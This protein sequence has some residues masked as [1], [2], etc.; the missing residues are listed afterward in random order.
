MKSIQEILPNMSFGGD[1]NPEQWDESVWKRDAELMKKAGVNLVSVGIFSWSVLETQEDQFEFEWL[2]RVLDLLYEHGIYA[3]LAT[4]TASPPAWLTKKYPDVTAVNE[5]GQPYHFGSRQHYSPNSPSYKRAVEKLVSALAERYKDH[6]GV[7]MWHINNEYGCHVSECYS[8]YSLYAFRD[9]LKK[10]YG[11]IEELNQA[12]GT[13]FWSQRYTEW[14]EIDFPVRQ[15]TFYNPG[16]KLDY[17]RFMNDSLFE[18]YMIEKRILRDV[19]PTI[20]VFTNFMYQFKP[21]DYHEWAK[22][23]DV[24][25]WDTYPDPREGVPYRHAFHHDLMRSLRHGQPFFIMEQAS[26]HVNWRDINLTKEPGE[27]RLWSYSAVARGAD[28]IMYFQ[29]RQGKAGAEKFHSAMIPH[30][31]S[32]ESRTYREVQA[33]GNELKKLGELTGS[34]VEAKVAILFDWENWWAV[35]LE[36]KPHNKLDYME[37]VMAYYKPLYDVNVAI[38]IVHPDTDLSG[39]E[40]VI[41]PMLY[42]MKESTAT[43]FETYVRKGGKMVFS[44]FSGI[45]DLHDRIYVGGYPGPIRKLLGLSIDEFVPLAEGEQVKL[46]DKSGVYAC[47]TWTE[48]IQL[49]NAEA[50]A[51]FTDTWLNEYPAVTHNRYGDGDVFYIGTSPDPEWLSEFILSRLKDA[52]IASPK[53][54]QEGLEIQERT[55]ENGRFLFLLNHSKETKTVKTGWKGVAL[56]KDE[57]IDDTLTI[58]SR[59][60]VIIKM[61]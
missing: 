10:R 3:C 29:W 45:A 25:T 28:A 43:S 22:E 20:P 41:A 14:S 61:S 11:T 40:L 12:W 52:G 24:V 6:P 7:K 36:G 26:G 30:S 5:Q 46:R 15:A 49:E 9:W 35:E 23:T 8:T 47:Q 58:E 27:M 4:A 50:L 56:L 17:K 19:T 34:K 31:D 37:T 13:S 53:A 39:Y 2:D 16:Q 55:G 21:L 48:S 18:L 60:V 59:E 33:L 51:A 38:D 42:A 54:H 57:P 44:Y 1:Y 32:E